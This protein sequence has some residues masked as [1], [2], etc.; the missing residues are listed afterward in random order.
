LRSV[1][2]DYGILKKMGARTA[3]SV[4]EYLHTSFPDLDREYRDG[5]L[6][7]RT[8]PDYLHGKVQL[9]IGA[10]FLMLRKRL[11]IYACSETRM[12]LGPSIFLIPDVAVFQG[13]E[14]AAIPDTPP[15]IAIE[16]LSPD[17]RMSAVRE[18]LEHYRN[19]G[20]PHA[21]LVDPHSRRLYTC[22]ARLSEVTHFEVPE[23]GI[24]VEPANIFDWE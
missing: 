21:W 5:E 9:I 18:K 23:L 17:D 24:T 7:E 11:G 16:I 4:E 20:V 12:R 10:F 8:L 3:I 19:W 22:D 15:L 14:P 2:G 6:L 1:A 13:S